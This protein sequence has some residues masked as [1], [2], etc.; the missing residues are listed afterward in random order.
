VRGHVD[1][2]HGHLGI[3]VDEQLHQDEEADPGAQH[4]GGIGVAC[5]MGTMLVGRPGEWQTRCR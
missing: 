1:L 3:G 5:L 2:A 4:L